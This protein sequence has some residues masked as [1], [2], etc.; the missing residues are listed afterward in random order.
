MVGGG[1]A[2]ISAAVR[3]AKLRNDVT[4]V[5]ESDHL[6]GQL[7]PLV[8]D[9]FSF[10]HGHSVFTLP[11]TLRDLFRKSG[12]PL[13][14]VLELEYLSP[15]RRHLFADRTVLN[16]PY[17]S[18]ADQT[19][20]IDD[21]LDG[22][23]ERW[24]SWLD[25]LVPVWDAVRRGALDVT[26]TGRGAFTKE[27]CDLLRPHRNLHREARKAFK[28]DRLRALALSQ[29]RLAGDDPRSTPALLAVTHLVE[30]NF[31]RWQVAGGT[32]ALLDALGKRL[33]ERKVDV[34]LDTR[35]LGVLTYDDSSVRGVES[36]H[37]A[38]ACD[39]VVWAAPAAPAGTPEPEALP[40]AP[41]ARTYLGLDAAAPYLPV[42]TIVH[43]DPPLRIVRSAT[44]TEAGQAWTVE[45]RADDDLLAALARAGLDV[46]HQVRSRTDVSPAD[47]VRTRGHADGWQWC[48]SRTGLHLPGVGGGRNGLF[49]VGVN[50]HPGPSLELIAMGTAA[51]ATEIGKA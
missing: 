1:F 39:L 32:D 19:E 44:H 37:G 13:E 10:D 25:R 7:R 20:A 28:D 26:F 51:V 42:E 49:R 8:T 21:A 46:R 17:G 47:S 41:P 3:I 14:R 31:G 5:E 2:G 35:A 33:A 4:L 27:Q 36:E 45:H 43:A 18:R 22:Q 34:R 38:I 30:R 50:A 6:G 15:G 48:G 12:R 40:T 9:G 11:A 24:T 29:P 23:G 16:L